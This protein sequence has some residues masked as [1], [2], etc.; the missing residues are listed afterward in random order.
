MRLDAYIKDIIKDNNLSPSGT[1]Y[2]P[3][4][5]KESFLRISIDGKVKARNAFKKLYL[6]HEAQGHKRESQYYYQ[7]QANAKIF[8]NA[9]AGG[10]KIKQFILGCKAGFNAITSTG[11]MSVKQG[12]SF[13]ERAVNGNI[14]LPTMKDALTYTL[15]HIRHIPEEFPN[16]I[17]TK[18]LYVPTVDEVVQYLT[19]SVANYTTQLDVT[20]LRLLLTN[21]TVVERSYVFYAGCINN[22]CRY[23]EGLMRPWIDS[24]FI[25][26]PI[27]PSL[28]EDIDLGE[29]KS[30]SRR[31][32]LLHVVH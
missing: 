27:D 7:N 10:M 31:C 18:T 11:R 13:I 20:D 6:D 12:Y 25:N 15:N 19:Q 21:S 29:V 26:G 24:C 3:I 32:Y 5:R 30:F 28:L 2:M 9:I 22:L 14:Y 16:L 8:N 1:C 23:N 4:S 17:E